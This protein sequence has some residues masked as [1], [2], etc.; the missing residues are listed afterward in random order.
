MYQKLLVPLDTSALAECTLVHV[1]AIAKGLKVPEVVLLSVLSPVQRWWMDDYAIPDDWLQDTE[2]KAID[3]SRKY[4][5]K[6]AD[7]LKKEGIATETS[8]VSGEPAEVIL[9]YVKK[10]PVD[11]IVMSTHG[12]SG[13]TRWLLGSVADRVIRYSTVPVLII[14][15]AGCRVD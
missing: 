3:S 8:V 6:M 11:L 5:A 13:V 1:Q 7:N 15:P 4:L 14:P 10:N 9:D 2:A 12:R